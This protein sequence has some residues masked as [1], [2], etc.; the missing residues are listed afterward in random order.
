MWCIDA[1][2]RAGVETFTSFRHGTTTVRL[3]S[4]LFLQLSLVFRNTL[5]E[6]SNE[7]WMKLGTR[8]CVAWYS[9]LCHLPVT[10]L[11]FLFVA[12]NGQEDGASR[13]GKGRTQRDEA[14]RFQNASKVGIWQKLDFLQPDRTHGTVRN[15]VVDFCLRLNLTFY[16]STFPSFS[17]FVIWSWFRFNTCPMA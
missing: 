15:Y 12:W 16:E 2:F 8:K 11:G 3:S 10:K 7:T 9:V 17:L 14:R 1:L 6:T 4:V 5:E 13:E